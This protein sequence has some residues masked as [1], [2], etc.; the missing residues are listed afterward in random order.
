VKRPWFKSQPVDEGF[1]ANAPFRLSETF[2][3]NKPAA[4][5]WADLTA[6]N[7]L[8]WCKVI[9]R[10]EWTS[11]RPFAVGTT[12]TVTALKGSNVLH[13]HFF[14]WDEG[15]RQ[16]FYV[17]DGSTPFFKRFAEDYVV[18][19]TGDSSCRFTWTIAAEFTAV[20]KAGA[21]VNKRLL[22]TLFRDTRKHY[23]S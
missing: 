9:D 8:S 16:A 15:R 12:R 14:I 17:I 3:I 6:D 10:I 21:P 18:E 2:A 13:E 5:V 20:G 11:P 4:D 1:L 19:P 7:P 23:A 22:Q